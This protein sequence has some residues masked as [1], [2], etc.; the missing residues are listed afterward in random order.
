MALSPKLELRQSQSLIMTPQLMQAIKLL[1]LSNIDLLAYVDA[2]LERNP[3]L[4][5]E[6][7]GGSD[8]GAGDGH[9]T[10]EGFDGEAGAGDRGSGDGAAGEPDR[11]GAGAETPGDLFEAARSGDVS[12]ISATLDTDFDNVFDPETVAP[13]N[14]TAAG[15]PATDSGWSTVRGD[16]Q[17]VDGDADFL[18]SALATGTSLQDH[19]IDQLSVAIA[20]PKARLIGRHL[21]DLVDENGYLTEAPAVTAERL[22]IDE[23]QVNGVLA[24]L[25]TF[26]PAGV[27]A[28]DLADC[29]AIQL[30][31]RNRYDPAMRALVDNLDLLARRDIPALKRVCGVDDEDVADMI[32]EL[33]R[34]DPKPGQAFGAEPVQPVVPDVFVRPG[35]DGGWQIELNGDTLPRVLIDQ[36][37]YSTVS[38]SARSESD[39]AYLSDCLQQANWLVRSLDQRARTILKVSTEIVRQQDAFLSQGVQSLRPLNL[40][41]VADAIRMHESTVSRVT[42]NKYMA[43]PR[44]IFELKYFFTTA[45]AATE[46]GDAHSAEAV[47]YRIKELID[48]ESAQDIL[49]DDAI[50]RVLRASG[51]DI[52]RRTVAKYREWMKIPSSV[53]RR[54][55]KRAGL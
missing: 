21:I 4:E 20:E 11:E 48:A 6:D 49:S 54:R 44:G 10:P 7:D 29:L 23:A 12:S 40:R 30:R 3:L 43:T 5:R 46:G 45:I 51:V 25:Q 27:C 16:R 39:R 42:S 47:R 19:L 35:P 1:Q 24:V 55:E 18:E 31:E 52:A 17:P 34:L 8:D 14:G 36:T 22:G 13:A 37:Y 28:R 53:Q 33:R 2:E 32:G 26:D 9:A 38:R 15:G 41:T 50:V